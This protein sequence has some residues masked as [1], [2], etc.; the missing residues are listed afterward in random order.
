MNYEHW[1]DKNNMLKSD[2]IGQPVE[3]FGGDVIIE[4]VKLMRDEISTPF[5]VCCD[6][7]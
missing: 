4:E 7:Y 6:I 3:I 2:H 1:N 5:Y